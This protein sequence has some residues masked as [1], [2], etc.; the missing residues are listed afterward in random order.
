MARRGPDWLFGGFIGAAIFG[1][2]VFAVTSLGIS[3]WLVDAM[4]PVPS[5]QSAQVIDDTFRAYVACKD[6]IETRGF[7][8]LA[9]LSGAL[10]VVAA[11]L[12]HSRKSAANTD[13]DGREA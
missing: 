7:S 11:R 13:G 1:V 12:R 3:R 9:V 2:L 8:V 6:S 5:N 4:C 10:V